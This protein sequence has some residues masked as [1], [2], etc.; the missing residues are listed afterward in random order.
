MASPSPPRESSQQGE[1]GDVQT[2]ESYDKRET[3]AEDQ[4]SPIAMSN[5]KRPASASRDEITEDGAIAANENTTLN[6]NGVTTDAVT[7]SGA[8]DPHD[9]STPPAKRRTLCGVCL[10]EPSKY[11]CSV[12]CSHIHRD[13]HPPDASADKK[14]TLAPP[15]PSSLPPKPEPP[16]HP[17]HVLDDAPELRRLFTRYPTLAARLRSIY[18]AT[19][20]PKSASSGSSGPN[21]NGGPDSRSPWRLPQQNT[22]GGGVRGGWGGSSTMAPFNKPWTKEMGLKQGQKALRRARVDP[23]E[24]GDAVRAYCETVTYLLARGIEDS[25]VNPT[26]ATT[27]GTS[28]NDL[29]SLV[30]K[31]MA[32]EANEVIKRLMDA[33][34]RQ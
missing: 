7:E 34:G 19:M 11:N 26:M 16:P 10:T 14:K 15:L 2:A 24:D 22:R 29:S 18:E 27:S 32:V 31:E 17:F 5:G 12:A 28:S 8:S 30:R 33:E 25:H 13:N 6:G 23:G 4:L 3:A 1:D 21:N 20:P 9:I